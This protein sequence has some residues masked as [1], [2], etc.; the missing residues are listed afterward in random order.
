MKLSHDH[1]TVGFQMYE[2]DQLSRAVIALYFRASTEGQQT[3]IRLLD[4]ALRAGKDPSVHVIENFDTN[5]E[6]LTGKRFVFTSRGKERSLF[7]DM[8]ASKRPGHVVA[9]DGNA[10]TPDP[11]PDMTDEKRIQQWRKSRRAV[12]AVKAMDEEIAS[13]TDDEQLALAEFRGEKEIMR[14]GDIKE[15]KSYFEAKLA[16][17]F[18]MIADHRRQMDAMV[19]RTAELELEMANQESLQGATRE[20]E[21]WECFTDQPAPESLSDR[22]RRLISLPN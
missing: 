19:E 9:E 3:N 5:H 15:L 16:E 4:A 8:N 1:K 14:R 17:A 13:L 11:P 20:P 12:I 7:I 2:I 10:Y 6:R 21:L 22:V 18:K